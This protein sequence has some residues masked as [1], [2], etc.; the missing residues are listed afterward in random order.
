[1]WE[2]MPGVYAAIF[3][4]AFA[5]GQTV[6]NWICTAKAR[7]GQ[8]QSPELT[9]LLLRCERLA[10]MPLKAHFVFDGDQRPSVKR[11]TL[12]RGTDHWSINPFK[13]I[14][15]SFGFSHS[16]VR[17]IYYCFHGL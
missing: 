14:L 15:D 4:Y 9:S 17:L 8:T 16:V 1:M 11:G 10:H 12:V 5:N 7:H 13:T 6:S 2:L 3:V